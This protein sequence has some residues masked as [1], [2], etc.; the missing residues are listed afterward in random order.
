MPNFAAMNFPE[1]IHYLYTRLPMFS[2]IGPAALKP[3]LDNTIAL[4]SALGNPEKKFKAIHVAGTNGKGSV[5]HT[6]AAILQTAGYKTGLY[7]SPHLYDFRERIRINGQMIAEEAVVE[8]VQNVQPIIESLEASFFELTLAMAFQHFAENGVDIALIETGLGGR[9]DSTNVIV[10]ELSIITNIG[11]DH[12]N[13]LGNTLPQ[14][15]AEKAG[16]IKEGVPVVVGERQM[17]TDRVFEDTA[18]LRNAPLF[19]APDHFEIKAYKA[20]PDTMEMEIGEIPAS[21]SLSLTLDLPGIYQLKNAQTT[22]MAVALLRRQGWNIEENHI[23]AAMRSVKGLTGLMGRWDVLRTKPLLVLEVAHNEAGMRQ[24]LYHLEH[25]SYKKLH[26]ILGMVKDKEIDAVLAL[27]PKNA[28]YYFTAAHIPRALDASHLQAQAS[29]MGLAG[30]RYEDVN[31]A[32]GAALSEADASD[33]IVVCGSVFLVGEADRE[34]W[35]A[36]K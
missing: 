6:L 12:M 18:K 17:E 8:F 19:F 34:R 13:I 24:M 3:S 30:K 22:L 36:K 2:R 16:I 28:V 4:C 7:T 1:T 5:S 31:S 11:W 10:P 23:V 15:A 33:I 32:I 21:K 25:Q 29:A 20:E 9:L 14:I 35:K 26:I 27:L